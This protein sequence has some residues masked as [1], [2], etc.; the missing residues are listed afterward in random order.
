MFRNVD[1]CLEKFMWFWGGG[2]A[3]DDGAVGVAGAFLYRHNLV[4][5]AA[6]VNHRAARGN[7]IDLRPELREAQMPARMS[8]GVKRNGD[9]EHA[10]RLTT[11]SVVPM[12]PKEITD[13]VARN[14]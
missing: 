14:D 5:Q 1:E 2:F 9:R 4:Q 10:V 3:A 7:L 12:A 6:G 11:R 8:V 13:R